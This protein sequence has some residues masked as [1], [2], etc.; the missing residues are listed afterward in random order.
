MRYCTPKIT[1][2]AITFIITITSVSTTQ[3][4]MY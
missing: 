4:Y 1:E 2:L 3:V